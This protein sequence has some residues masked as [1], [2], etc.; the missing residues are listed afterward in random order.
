MVRTL[1]VAT[2]LLLACAT[3]TGCDED[4]SGSERWC[5]G[6][7]S[8]VFRCGFHPAN[9]RAECVVDRP[10]LASLSEAAASSEAS[11]IS[12][13]SC[14]AIRNEE[15]W[16]TETSACWK[17]TVASV[18]ST[19]RSREFCEAETRAWFDCGYLLSNEECA[20]NYAL[21]SDQ[22]LERMAACARTETC[23]TLTD[24]ERRAVGGNQ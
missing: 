3:L 2:L 1:R 17:E 12:Q 21:W 6:L 4:L 16:R 7:C 24:C 15:T 14:A 18:A 10:G 11:C 13:V 20:K 5:D 9:C 19:E 8:A 23:A 22:V